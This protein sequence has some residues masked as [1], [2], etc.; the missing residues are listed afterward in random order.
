MFKIVGVLCHIAVS[1]SDR[2]HPSSAALGILTVKLKLIDSLSSL[3]SIEKLL[4]ILFVGNHIRVALSII[5]GVDF[6]YVTVNKG[7]LKISIY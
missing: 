5:I 4:L 2:L 6:H 1:V 7:L 3:K